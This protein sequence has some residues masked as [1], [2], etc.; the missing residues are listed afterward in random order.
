[1]IHG[2]AHLGEAVQAPLLVLTALGTAYHVVGLASAWR[3]SR[4]RAPEPVELPPI[5]VLKPV[6]GVDQDAWENFAS[7]CRQDYPEYELVFGIQDPDDPA[8]AVIERLQAEFPK[9]AIRL[10]VSDAR[11]GPN[12]K[13]CNL[14]N[15]LGEAR[16]DLL[17]LSDS[18]IRVGPGYLREVAAWATQPGTGLVTSLYQSCGMRSLPA[19]LE[20]L[21][22]MADFLP[23]VAVACAWAPPSFGLGATL[24]LRRETLDRAGGFPAVA[25]Y[26]ADDYELGRRVA[27]AGERVALLTVLPETQAP[28]NGWADA[29]R[30]RLRWAR[31]LRV[32]Q[33]AGY[34][35]MAVTYST[36]WA[37]AYAAAA[38]F[39]GPATAFL[40]M[41]QAVRMGTAVLLCGPVFGARETL[42]WLWALPLNDLLAAGVWAASWFGNGVEWRGERFR[43][44]RDGRLEPAPRL[45]AGWEKLER[46]AER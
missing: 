8:R 4:R 37:L 39:A 9:R 41:Q 27:A 2:P 21:G 38:G 24:A 35:G 28:N 16:H 7:F 5:S 40:L 22:L 11:I 3:L 32:C 19:G 33:P 15:I 17:V 6:C 31:T 42:R 10:V 25:A 30:H 13:V 26:L 14:Q 36:V 1:M 46:Q 34:A 20:A 45:A 12:R 18:D 43:V 29:I 23:G 44:G